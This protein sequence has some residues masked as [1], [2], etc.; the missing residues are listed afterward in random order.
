MFGLIDA[1]VY[2]F[3]SLITAALL[4]AI[5]F[6]DQSEV[7]RTFLESQAAQAQGSGLGSAVANFVVRPLIF[8]MDNP[9]GHIIAGLLWP[10]LVLWLLLL[11]LLLT[12]A[13]IAPGIFRARS[14]IS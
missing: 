9:A 7:A 13:F 11:V 12:F 3:I 6:F 1:K 5:N 8:A 2:A 14:T 10:V 4:A